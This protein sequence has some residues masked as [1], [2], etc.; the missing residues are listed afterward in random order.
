[1]LSC[2]LKTRTVGSF[3]YQK[4]SHLFLIIT[5]QFAVNCILQILVNQFVHFIQIFSS[6]SWTLRKELHMQQGQLQ[7]SLSSQLLH[8]ILF[9]HSF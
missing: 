7:N 4:V 5:Y 8:A 1:M 6:L 9:I 3:H 2:F